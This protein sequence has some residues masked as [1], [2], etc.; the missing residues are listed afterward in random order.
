MVRIRSPDQRTALENTRDS[1]ETNYEIGT[2]TCKLPT[3]TEGRLEV[4]RRETHNQFSARYVRRIVS[5]EGEINQIDSFD[6]HG[7]HSLEL[8]ES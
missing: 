8:L 1:A 7:G 3:K 4:E 6:T 2:S 5:L